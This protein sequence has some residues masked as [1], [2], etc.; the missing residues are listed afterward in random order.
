MALYIF[1]M[2]IFLVCTGATISS[3][4]AERSM[5]SDRPMIYWN[6]GLIKVINLFWV[7]AVLL[8]IVLMFMDWLTTLIVTIIGVIAGRSVLK[9]VAEIAVVLPLAKIFFR[10]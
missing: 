9:P 3:T 2:I 8:F 7:P 5:P 4:L 1:L 6:D 10:R